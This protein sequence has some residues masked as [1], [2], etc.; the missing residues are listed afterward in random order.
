MLSD[1]RVLMVKV[2]GRAQKIYINETKLEHQK[3]TSSLIVNNWLTKIVVIYK[4]FR[5]ENSG[6]DSSR[7]ILNDSSDPPIIEIKKII[8]NAYEFCE[9]GKWEISRITMKGSITYEILGHEMLITISQALE[10][11]FL[12][13]LLEVYQ[14]TDIQVTQAY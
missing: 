3:R 4:T 8:L 6:P 2:S 9:T 5:D 12:N 10:G 11:Q 13:G 1:S 7:H 14:Q